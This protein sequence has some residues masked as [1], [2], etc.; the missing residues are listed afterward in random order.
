MRSLRLVLTIGVLGVMAGSVALAADLAASPS[1]ARDHAVTPAEPA[2]K[3]YDKLPVSFIENRGQTD[4][5]VAYYAQGNGFGFYLTPSEVMLTFANRSKSST[6]AGVAL[7]LRFLGGNANVEPKGTDRAAGVINDLRGSDPQQWKTGIAQ[8][9]DVVYPDLWPG[10]DAQLSERSGVLKYEFHVRPGASPSDIQLAYDG[11]DSL[12][13]DASGALQIATP[14]GVLDDSIPVSYQQ[15]GGVR[16]PVTS[17]YVLGTGKGFAFDIGSYRRDQELII[18]PGVQYATFLGGNSAE[19]PGG[20]VVNAGGNAFVAGTT[21]SPDFPTTAGAFDRTGA[22]QNVS[23]VFVTKLNPAG[24]GLVY[25]T[26]VG[27][28]DLETGTGIAVDA[29]G[30]A[31]VTGTTKSS[32]FPTTAGAFDRTLNIPPNCPRCVVDN[33]DN[34]VFK[35]NAA[36]S[37]LAYSTYLGGTDIDSARGIAIDGSGNAYVTGETTSVDYPTTAAAFSRTAKGSNEVVVTKLNPTGSALVYS[38]FIGGTAADDA[39]RVAVDSGGNAYV[40]GFSASTDYP[41][42]AGAFDTTQNGVFDVTLTKL[43]PAGSALVYST[44]LGGSD[45]DSASGLAVDA[46]GSAYVAGGTPSADFPTTAGAYDRTL[47][48]ND[49]FVTKFNPAG[50]ALVYSTFLGGSD[51]DSINAIVLDA[52]NNAWLGGGTSSVDFPVTP[53]ATDATFNG[54]GDATIAEL[55]AAGSAVLFATYLGGSS[56]ESASGIGRDGT[57]NIYVTGQTM[58]QD[59][60]ATVGAFDRVWNGDPQ[61]FWGDGFVSKIDLQATSSTP[62]SPPSVPTA[63][64]LVSPFNGSS[65][66][67]QPITFDWND[68]SSA[69][70]YTLQIDDSSGFTAPLVREI[71]VTS[72][73]AVASG[74]ATTTHFW[75]VRGINSAGVAGPWSA[76]RSF[77]PQAA[78]APAQLSTI[79]LNPSTVVGG[80][81]SSGTVVMDSSATDGAV[82]SLSS[83]NPAVA[84]VPATTTVAPNGFTGTFTISTSA[85]TT[86]TTV[87]ITATYNGASRAGTLTVTPAGSTTT[88]L[89]SVMISPSSVTGGNN[90]SG[91]VSLSSG[92]PAGG[93]VVSL[94]SSNPSLASVQA[95]VTVPQGTTAVGFPVTTAT[96]SAT[97]TVTITATYAGVSVSAT[98]TLT[99]S[100]PPPPPPQTVTL[101]V[102][103]TGRSGERVVSSPT[104]ISVTTGTTGSASFASGTSITLSDAGGRD[105]I[106]SG[107]CSSGGS[108]TKTCTFTAN[109]NATVTANVQ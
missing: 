64:V 58:S 27:G 97:T 107:A 55:N 13:L 22:P 38:T 6:P 75:R 89:Q 74:L 28:S 108:K 71:N 80:N 61:I 31:Y 36:G 56:G 76:V 40:L 41:T 92:A 32:N 79:D 5:R 21:Q 34:F 100:A 59:F 7:G 51:F 11:A 17:R 104:G 35:L 84:S 23:D 2:A 87:T 91:V 52:S 94:S 25:S 98:L 37:A 70:S 73:M 85:V 60:P 99:A 68:A 62:T 19:T 82:V 46:A 24:N 29:A 53:D 105:V 33:T 9:G 101:T 102:T 81:A 12:T 95:S 83:S 66:E 57:G 1:G 90:T 77:V 15:I 63:P 26:F 50:S 8:Y 45:F 20:I 3:S 86:T 96:V 88:T 109:G 78:P 14:I 39:D 16:V 69:V 93:A 106:W 43:N 47:N 103:A 54:G 44:F 49:G 67:Q 30:N 4:P 18:D 65:A 72:S 10:I 48:N 42:T